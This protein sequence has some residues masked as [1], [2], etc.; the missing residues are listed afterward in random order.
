MNDNDKKLLLKLARDSIETFFS[1]GQEPDVSG[2]MHFDK[3]QGVF[4]TIHKNKQL[5]GCIGYPEPVMPLYKAIIEAARS[6]AFND[7]RF[8]MLEKEEL[9]S[10][11]IEVSVLTIPKVIEVD[12]SGDYRRRIIIGED[13]LIIRSK[14]GSGLLL[15]QVA[16]EHDFTVFIL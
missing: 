7:H 10:I 12:E 2:V 16:T 14:R 5:R 9:R 4:V 11:H 8:P 3:N 1:K 13:G 6:A 15:P